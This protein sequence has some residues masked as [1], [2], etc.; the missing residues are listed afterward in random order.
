MF[1]ATLR[2]PK[3]SRR[4][5]HPPI[6]IVQGFFSLLAA[7]APTGVQLGAR[8]STSLHCWLES[9]RVGGATCGLRALLDNRATL[10]LEWTGIE[11]DIHPA[12]LP[13]LVVVNQRERRHRR[14]CMLLIG[15]IVLVAWT[16]RNAAL[17][18]HPA[19]H[20]RSIIA[21]SVAT[22][23]EVRRDDDSAGASLSPT[24]SPRDDHGPRDDRGPNHQ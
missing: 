3:S 1:H 14:R 5:I 4:H 22:A 6:P 24:H 7:S 21:A 15:H 9:R 19:C 16:P 23:A 17:A 10:T 18:A 12:C 8:T 13:I 11:L 2:R 20:S